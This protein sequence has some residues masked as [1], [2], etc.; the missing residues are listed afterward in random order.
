MPMPQVNS[1][2]LPRLY[3]RRLDQMV[4]ILGFEGPATNCLNYIFI[5]VFMSLFIT[6]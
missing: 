6:Y 1:E 3:E 4:N 2:I 5:F